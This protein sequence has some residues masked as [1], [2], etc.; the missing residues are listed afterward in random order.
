[1][2]KLKITS[3]DASGQ[4][5][6]RYTSQQYINGAYV[7]GTGGLTSQVGRQIQGQVYV[8]GGSSTTG[9]ILAQK[10][11]KAFRVQ[12]SNSLVGECSLVNN[13]NLVAGQMNILVT[14]IAATANVT[15]A[16][17]AGGATSTY[18]TWDTRATNAGPLTTPRVGDYIIGLTGN[19]AVAQITAINSASNVTIATSGNVAGQNGATVSSCTYAKRISNKFVIDYNGVKFR[20]HLATPD[21][22]FVQVQYA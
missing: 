17:V 11:S 20:Y 13:P 14:T 10:G 15:A 6:D 21:S 12:D 16:N 22:T 3:T 5:H 7:G 9:S 4:I 19:A 8:N 2:A 1:M 18:V